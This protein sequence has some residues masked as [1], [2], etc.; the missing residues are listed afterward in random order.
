M[1]LTREE[2]IAKRKKARRRRRIQ[3]TIS[4]LMVIS[5]LAIASCCIYLWIQVKE[6]EN[7]A[8]EAVNMMNELE[9]EMNSGNYVTVTEAERMA[10]EAR[11]EAQT[12]YLANIRSMMENGDS[13]LTMLETLYPDKIIAADKGRYYFFDINK[14]LEKNIFDLEDL[15]YPVLNEETAD[16]EGE[17]KWVQNGETASKKG[18]DVSKFQGKI[19]WQ[20]VRSIYAFTGWEFIGATAVIGAN[21]G[22]NVL[23]GMFFNPVVNAA[24]GVAVQVQHVITGFVTNFQT[25][26]NPQITKSYASNNKGYMFNLIFAS[27]R[28]SYFLLFF[29]SLPVVLETDILLNL[30]L[31]KVP[32][33]TALF[34]R[35]IIICSMIDAISNPIS[36]SV[37][38]TGNIRNFQMVVG[39]TRL[40]IIPI[41]YL[42]LKIGGSPIAA[43]IVLLIIN[44]LA[45]IE[46]IEADK[47]RNI[48]IKF[49]Y[50]ILDTHTFKYEDNRVHNPYGRKGKN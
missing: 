34:F 35:I 15:V 47:N 14:N 12:E 31:V 46:R 18:I 43:F 45:L 29:I 26:L 39:L 19:D 3:N 13:T 27:S 32:E 49:R 38:A 44:I 36:T 5:V 9:E 7:K 20:K 28:L 42:V 23:L 33:Y 50:D 37:E 41:T 6:Q 24:H 11:Q 2:K 48:I 10:D 40:M 21:Q 16:Y 22:L 17:A 4:M 1:E 8:M 25:A 30:W